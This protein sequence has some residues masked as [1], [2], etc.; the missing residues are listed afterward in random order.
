MTVFFGWRRDLVAMI[1]AHVAVDTW[2]L[3]ITP[4]VSHWWR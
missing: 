2:G 4:A 1:V 3:V